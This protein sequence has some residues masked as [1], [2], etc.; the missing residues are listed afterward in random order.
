[1][2]YPH[3]PQYNDQAVFPHGP[4]LSVTG[5]HVYRGKKLPEFNGVYFYGDFAM[6]TLWGLRFQYGKIT[7]LGA[8][9]EMPSDIKPR[10]SISGFGRDSEG[11]IY[12]LSFDGKIYSLEPIAQG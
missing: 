4:G 1:M 10:R 9:V 8:V 2:E 5:G 12:I 6:G 7:H 3:S 11:E